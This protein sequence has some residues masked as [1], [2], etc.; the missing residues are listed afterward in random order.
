VF[1]QD[2]RSVVVSWLPVYHDMGLIGG[3]LQPIAARSRCVLMPP[4]AF[5][6][7]P[8]RWLRAITRYAA[9]T[10]AGPNFAYELC[11]QKIG[12]EQERGLDLRTWAHG[13]NGAEPVHAATLERFA[14][15]F[16]AC[17]FSREAFSPCYGLAEATLL[18]S[19][20]G[21]GPVVQSYDAG[22]LEK[23]GAERCA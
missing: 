4:T 1:G 9:T 18:V 15:R 3:L 22:A 2:A 16:R 6:R 5:L 10:S 20:G 11:V 8:V 12:P 7:S 23:G 14:E 19:G 17:G 13:L 21:S